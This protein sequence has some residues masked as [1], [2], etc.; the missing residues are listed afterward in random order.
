MMK[1]IAGWFGV[2]CMLAAPARSEGPRQIDARML[3]SDDVV[4]VGRLG[5]PLG[6]VVVIEAALRYEL[7]LNPFVRDYHLVVYRVDGV[8]LPE[9][10]SFTY[11]KDV[12]SGKH[13]VPEACVT[14]TPEDLE[15]PEDVQFRKGKREESPDTRHVLWV[16]EA[17]EFSGRPA[18]LPQGMRTPLPYEWHFTFLTTLVV[19]H[20]DAITRFPTRLPPERPRVFALSGDAPASVEEYWAGPCT[21]MYDSDPWITTRPVELAAMMRTELVAEAGRRTIATG[22]LERALEVP[23][24]THADA[25][26]V[27][28]PVGAILMQGRDGA[29]WVITWKEFRWVEGPAPATGATA[30]DP[31]GSMR[32]ATQVT[33]HCC[34]VQ[35]GDGRVVRTIELYREEDGD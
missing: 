19:H 1:R 16:H 31:A 18:S 9:P 12:G 8:D 11:R 29:A 2:A 30:R 14:L 23:A 3:G 32:W 17:A 26:G 20:E 15:Q 27:A 22:G 28:V 33:H 10:R 21:V 4:V 24:A 6:T 35:A 7:R 34:V 13:G 25:G 5:R